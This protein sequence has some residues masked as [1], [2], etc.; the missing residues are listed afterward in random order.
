V[1]KSHYIQLH[2]VEKLT[3]AEY[4][5]DYQIILNNNSI[6]AKKKN[7]SAWNRFRSKQTETELP[8]KWDNAFSLNRQLKTLSHPLK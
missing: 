8:L 3:G 7:P 2:H 4:N 5:F 6:Q 1:H